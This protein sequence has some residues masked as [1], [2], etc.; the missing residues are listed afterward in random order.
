MKRIAIFASGAGSNA[1]KIIHYFANHPTI[2]VAMV[3][4]NKPGAGVIDI[5]KQ[6]DVF[7]L[8]IEKEAFFYGD[9]YLG[10]LK[11]HEIDFIV[12]A[13]FLWKIPVG[14][15]EA[16]PEKIINIHPALLPSYG[17]KGMYGDFVH[18]AV[19]KA[20]ETQSGITVHLVDEIYDNGTTI[21]TATC[22][23]MAN[24]TPQTLALRIHQLE[25]KF[26]P[27]VIER[28]ITNFQDAQS[29]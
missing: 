19:I 29:F 28:Y 20:G 18:E 23:V 4:S 10:K 2:S 26:Y 7:V 15:I 11:N 24:D 8:L 12:L 17:G 3:I 6:N 22:P 25:H 14:L 16:F 9:N 27:Q 1:E 21:F 13:G 5:A